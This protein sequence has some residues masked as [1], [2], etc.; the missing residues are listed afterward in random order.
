MIKGWLDAN[1]ET[2]EQVY[3]VVWSDRRVMDADGHLPPVGNTVDLTTGAYENSIGAPEL[4]ALW[5][6]PDFDAA[7]S[8]FYYV[9]VLQIPTPRHSLYDALALGIDPTETGHPATLQERA[10]SSAIWYKP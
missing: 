2:Q 7:Q 8:A 3:D 5:Q 10:Y 9:R 6:D 4:S 1:G